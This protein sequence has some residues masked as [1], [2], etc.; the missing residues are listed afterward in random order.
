MAAELR[1]LKVGKRVPKTLEICFLPLL[2]ACA[3][4]GAGA[5]ATSDAGAGG[6]GGVTRLP[7]QYPGLYLFSGPSR[8][9]RPVVNLALEK[10][11]WIGLLEQ[12]YLAVAV[13]QA[14]IDRSAGVFK[15]F[16]LPIIKLLKDGVFVI[17]LML[18]CAGTPG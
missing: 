18:Y 10:L 8:L 4:A 11:E 3:D 12:V 1:C 14:D 9:V 5:G 13:E 7:G 2:E 6:S 15:T 17:I 16:T